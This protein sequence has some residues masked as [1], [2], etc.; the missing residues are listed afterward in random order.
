M[1]GKFA[2]RVGGGGGAYLQE[3]VC[4]PY[5]IAPYS[6]LVPAM[7]SKCR[8]LDAVL[9]FFHTFNSLVE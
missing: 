7:Q 5:I 9:S 6:K 2:G 4:Y 3:V 1:K 8:G